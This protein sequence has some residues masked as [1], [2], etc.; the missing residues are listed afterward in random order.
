MGRADVVAGATNG[1]K[2]ALCSG[3]EKQIDSIYDAH[4]AAL[5][6][7]PSEESKAARAKDLGLK[8]WEH[9]SV[10][11][12]KVRDHAKAMARPFRKEKIAVVVRD[13][14]GK[15][16]RVTVTLGERM[17]EHHKLIEECERRLGELENRKRDV[18]GRIAEKIKEI[19]APT[20][21]PEVEQVVKGL[22]ER[23]DKVGG[24]MLRFYEDAEGEEKRRMSK[25]F[26]SLQKA[27]NDEGSGEVVEE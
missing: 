2:A 8:E 3:A 17:E 18:E 16:R 12:H 21:E 15:S 26:A 22:K 14:N 24:E 9:P 19:S 6:N 11:Y 5:E 10:I 27:F 23:I 20:L 13:G 7:G 25:V 1:Y 4:V